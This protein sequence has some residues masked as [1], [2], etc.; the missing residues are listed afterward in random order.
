MSEWSTGQSKSAGDRGK[1]GFLSE[2]EQANSKSFKGEVRAE[3]L[4]VGIIGF[5]K[6]A[7]EYYIPA[8]QSLSDIRV[9][10]VAD[11]L[12]A[13]QQ[14]VK[15]LI[16]DAQSYSASQ[17]LFG[18]E[19][20]DAVL[21]ASPPSTHLEI[22]REANE[23]GVPVFMEKPFILRD[24]IAHIEE[25]RAASPRLMINFN[26]RFWPTYQ[27]LRDRVH[28][29]EIGKL[30]HA[31]FVLHVNIAKWCSVTQHRLNPSEGG[32][33]FDIGSQILDLARTIVGQE[34]VSL[35]AK[36]WKAKLE[37]DHIQ[38]N[39][40]F[41]SGC[42]AL[43][44]VAYSEQTQERVTVEGTSA[45]LRLDNPNMTIHREPPASSVQ[46]LFDYVGDLISFGHKVLRRD[47]SML[48]FT[49]RESIKTFI[50]SLRSGESFSPG[51]EEA[52][53]IATYLQ[54]AIQSSAN[55]KV[56]TVSKD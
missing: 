39:L 44:D 43:C 36:I 32:A 29:G 8:L 16:P 7:Q 19:R 34:P 46:H 25:L 49:V 26:R 50:H 30:K 12:L 14:G 24:E 37:D 52:V 35:E 23:L 10:A 9:V 55:G 33:L 2:K 13:S 27:S 28:S 38:I 22:W 21:I 17:E 11:P 47:Q 15:R 48:R 31:E 51:L 20:L 6:L 5:G 42:T 41:K 54:A 3:V 40:N 56:V 18:R 45:K 53:T 4:K 1:D